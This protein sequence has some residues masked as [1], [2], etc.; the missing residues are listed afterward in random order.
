[1]KRNRWV[2]A[3]TLFTAALG[4]LGMAAPG[5][6]A[7]ATAPT[8]F[9]GT[10]GDACVGHSGATAGETF[11]L[12]WRDTD[13][14]L[15]A[16]RNVT[17]DS[18]GA[19]SVCATDHLL[20]AGDKLKATNDGG[21]HDLVVPRLTIAVNRV[22]NYLSGRGPANEAVRLACD[23][24]N[25]FEPCQW[26]DGV[27]VG[28]KGYWSLKLPFDN[29]PTGGDVYDA[30][31]A[32]G[33]GD[34]IT[35][36]GQAPFVTAE[37]GSAK[38]SGAL[39]AGKTAKIRLFDSSMALKGTAVATGAF[40]ANNSGSFTAVFRDSHG[41]PVDVQP[42]DTIDAKKL[43]TDSE[44]VVP[45]IVATATASNDRVKGQCEN[46][47]ASQGYANVELYR[48]GTQRGFAGFEGE[49]G[50]FSFNFRKVRFGSPANVKPGDRVVID[51][52]QAGGD[53]VLLAIHAN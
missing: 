21:T 34:H 19:W 46:T 31:W 38:V 50:A 37:L 6:V 20:S 42:G 15:V 51:C 25:G 36:Y 3:T 45:T 16:R 53:G 41:N 26:H 13:G 5:V 29:P 2:A 39:D 35:A 22:H 8:T 30:S 4:M 24:S 33:D 7:A 52:I 18:D 14:A 28:P 17:V 43:S 9:D 47:P 11:K 12:V 49:D 32:S 10:M 44:F 23:F 48:D 40:E 1:M 27:R